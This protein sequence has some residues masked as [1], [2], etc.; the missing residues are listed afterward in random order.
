M[1]RAP[2]YYTKTFI[3]DL[4]ENAPE[5]AES[6]YE[7]IYDCIHS[8]ARETLGEQVK[9]KKGGRKYKIQKLEER[10]ALI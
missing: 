3:T 6:L 1:R 4:D 7:C 5:S 10:K 9:G 2:K 8:A